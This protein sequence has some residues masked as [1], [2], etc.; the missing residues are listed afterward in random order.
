MTADDTPPITLPATEMTQLAALLT[1]LR[2]QFPRSGSLISEHLAAF[3]SRHGHVDAGYLANVLVDEVAFAD[4]CLR[5]LAGG[6]ASP[7]NRYQPRSVVSWP[8]GRAIGVCPL[9]VTEMPAKRSRKV[10]GLPHRFA[11]HPAP[12]E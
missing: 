4:A 2:G 6:T 3:F 12:A 10:S 8:Y 1:E 5:N 11:R 7:A 9:A